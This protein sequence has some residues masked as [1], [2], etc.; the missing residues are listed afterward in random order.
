[1]NNVELWISAWMVVICGLIGII[2]F[3]YYRPWWDLEIRTYF[4]KKR[5][6]KKEKRKFIG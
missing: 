6:L 5:L 3:T 2:T 4:T 1:M